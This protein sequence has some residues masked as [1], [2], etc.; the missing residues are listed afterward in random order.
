MTIHC[1]SPF[2]HIFLR[3]PRHTDRRWISVCCE[4]CLVLTSLTETGITCEEELQERSSITLAC[5]QVYGLFSMWEGP[6]H[7]GPGLYKEHT[8]QALRSKPVPG[9]CMSSRPPVPA[10]ASFRDGLWSGSQTNPLLPKLILVSVLPQQTEMLT[11]TSRFVGDGK[12]SHCQC[13]WEIFLRGWNILLPIFC[14]H[15]IITVCKTIYLTVC[16]YTHI[17]ICKPWCLLL[18]SCAHLLKNI[19]AVGEFYVM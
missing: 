5:E 6:A 2:T 17:F 10:F 12:K 14:A 9:L 8:G 13:I 11:R 1:G 4:C 15:T 3:R 16:I 18:D 7:C 19:S